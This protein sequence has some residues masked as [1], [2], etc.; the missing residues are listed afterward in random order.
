MRNTFAGYLLN[1]MDRKETYLLTG[2]LGFSAFEKIREK[3]H[4]YFMNMGISEQNMI[5]VAAGLLHSGKTVFVYSIIPFLV[6]RALEQIRNDV[7]YANL[8][9][10]IIGVGA[11]F[12]YSDAGPTHHSTEDVS[13][14]SSLPNLTVLNPSDPIQVKMLL[15]AANMVK[16]PIY[17][18][19][20]KNGEPILHSEEY[21]LEI[22]KA[23]KLSE[24]NEILI[25]STGTI[26]KNAISV[27]KML[28]K[29]GLSC[30]LLEIH[31]PKPFDSEFVASSATSKKLIVTIEESTGWLFSSVAQA[32]ANIK[33]ERIVPFKLPDQFVH[34]SSQKKEWLWDYYG[35]SVS[36][37]Y[38]KIISE[39]DARI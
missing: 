28:E 7:C 14:M 38:K 36:S 22:G 37:I 24:G 11:G 16:G 5:G 6:F 20:G 23:S 9:A 18:R 29:N 10:R 30:D 21:S 4:R 3:H 34:I 15:E 32:L 31:T 19:L 33:H 12:S 17:M 1:E 39:I 8:P 26:L 27:S 25:V 13:V 2:D 35:L